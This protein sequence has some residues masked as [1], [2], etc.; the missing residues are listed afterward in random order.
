MVTYNLGQQDIV[1]RDTSTRVNDG[2]YHVVRFVR[3]GVNS[4]LQVDDNQ[5][6]LSPLFFKSFWKIWLYFLRRKLMARVADVADFLLIFMHETEYPQ[7]EPSAL[8]LF[9]VGL[10]IA[11][12]NVEFW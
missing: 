6:R 5:V 9:V 4:S 3:T 7:N 12:A 8:F 11:A 1:I 10:E 2:K